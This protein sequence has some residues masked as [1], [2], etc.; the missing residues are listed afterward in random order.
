LR[1]YQL[2]ENSPNEEYGLKLL[3]E[4]VFKN[5]RINS[6]YTFLNF[7]EPGNL[8]NE[9]NSAPV[10]LAFQGGDK[11]SLDA[12]VLE[13]GELELANT[14]E[15]YHRTDFSAIRRCKDGIVSI[16]FEGNMNILKF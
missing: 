15:R 4:R 8:T 5:Q 2:Y 14:K 11:F 6:M 13:N 9:G 16:D 1:L 7:Y 3:A 12:Y 10:I